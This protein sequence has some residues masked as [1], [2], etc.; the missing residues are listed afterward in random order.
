[1]LF[2]DEFMPYRREALDALHAPLED[3]VVCIASSGGIIS[4]PCG[5]SLI[6]AMNPCRCSD[7]DVAHRP[8]QC[9]EHQ[10]E[11]YRARLSGP[12][13]DHEG[14]PCRWSGTTASDQKDERVRIER[15]TV[16]PVHG[17][18]R[19]CHAAPRRRR[20]ERLATTSKVVWN[21]GRVVALR[22]EAGQ[23]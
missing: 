7:L 6:S 15:L 20:A 14:V 16:E 1:M 21:W 13:L 19:S 2:L 8:C 10:L 22:G 23:S 3:G 5:F 12:L 18:V 4:Y 17:D 9:A 11:T